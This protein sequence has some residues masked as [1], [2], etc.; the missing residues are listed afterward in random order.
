MGAMIGGEGTGPR[1]DNFD[2]TDFSYWRMQINDYLHSKKLHQPLSGKKP[3]K[4][5]NDNWE[6]LDR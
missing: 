4:I 2:S 1:I 3:E 6:L 5:E